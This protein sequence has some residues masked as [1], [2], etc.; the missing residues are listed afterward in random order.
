MLRSLRGHRYRHL[1]SAEC[2]F[3]LLAVD[4]LG[5]GPAF[6]RIEYDHRPARS[7][8]VPLNPRVPLDL[9]DL[10]Q[11]DIER[12]GHGLM[13]QVWLVALDVERRPTVATKQSV[14]LFTA[15][16]GEEGGV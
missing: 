16:A 8:G 3:D 14:Q 5:A 7:C 4:N 13:H 12:G 6:R 1:M 9:P 11:D 2:P 10:L 15:D